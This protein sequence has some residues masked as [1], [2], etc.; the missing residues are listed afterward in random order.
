MPK[1][2]I[3]LLYIKHQSELKNNRRTPCFNRFSVDI[4]EMEFKLDGVRVEEVECD[5]VFAQHS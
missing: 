1:T 2:C 3:V 5:N 4:I